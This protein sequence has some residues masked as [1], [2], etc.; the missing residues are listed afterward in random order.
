MVLTPVHALAIISGFLPENK[1]D[2]VT[3]GEDRLHHSVFS[4][5]ESAALLKAPLGD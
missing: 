2:S 4:T 3:I 1:R 5:R